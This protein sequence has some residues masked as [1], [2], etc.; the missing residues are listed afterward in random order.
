MAQRPMTPDLSMLAMLAPLAPLARRPTAIT[1]ITAIR[2]DAI[3]AIATGH[4]AWS[5]TSKCWPAKNA[6]LSCG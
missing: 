4:L 2:P 3:T 6:W 1:A 5:V